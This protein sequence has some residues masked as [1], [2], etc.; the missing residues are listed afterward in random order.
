VADVVDKRALAREVNE[1]IH[2]VNASFGFVPT[3]LDLLCE[4]ERGDCLERLEVTSSVY[5]EIRRELERFVVAPGHEGTERV[6]AE[7]P[8]YRIVALTRAEAYAS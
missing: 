6:V 5:E 2:A 4:C 7:G 3:T 8:E 1:R